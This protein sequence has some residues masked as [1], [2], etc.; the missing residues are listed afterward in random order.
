MSLECE[1]IKAAMSLSLS[2]FGLLLQLLRGILALAWLMRHYS[3][4]R[5]TA[6]S[7]EMARNDEVKRV[8]VNF[9]PEAFEDL[10]ELARAEGG[11]TGSE[12]LRRAISLSKWFVD[13][14]AN[15]ANIL[16]ERNG[17]LREVIKL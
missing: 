8:S 17:K 1:K 5:Y 9:S 10:E 14:R 15:G 13:Q 2:F 3:F 4:L 16:V 12:A 6:R 7:A 11:I